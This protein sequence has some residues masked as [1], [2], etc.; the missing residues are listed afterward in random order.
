MKSEK[1]LVDGLKWR[2][3]NFNFYIYFIQSHTENS[4]KGYT[5]Q[6]DAE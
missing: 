2:Q 1:L 4:D 5:L 3:N 6:V